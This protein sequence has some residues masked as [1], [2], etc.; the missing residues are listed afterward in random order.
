MSNVTWIMPLIILYIGVLYG[1][2]LML[3]ALY[4]LSK[5]KSMGLLIRDSVIIILV[6]TS[7][8][9]GITTGHDCIKRHIHLVCDCWSTNHP[10][11]LSKHLVNIPSTDVVISFCLLT[12]FGHA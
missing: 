7:C 8:H 1:V 10:I 11:L 5:T 3:G 12:M 9:Y 2:M 6:L 4:G